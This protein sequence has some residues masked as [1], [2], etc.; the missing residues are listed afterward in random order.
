MSTEVISFK[1]PIVR[2]GQSYDGVCLTSPPIYDCDWCVIHLATRR[3]THRPSRTTRRLYEWV[4]IAQ[5]DENRQSRIEAMRLLIKNG[6]I[7]GWFT[8]QLFQERQGAAPYFSKQFCIAVGQED[9]RK[10]KKF[11]ECTEWQ[12]SWWRFLGDFSRLGGCPVLQREDT[13]LRYSRTAIIHIPTE[14]ILKWFY[15]V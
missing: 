14:M 10:L 5:Y 3:I 12:N 8:R 6:F 4:R 15:P 11:F 13:I 9:K 7:S 1:A 2:T